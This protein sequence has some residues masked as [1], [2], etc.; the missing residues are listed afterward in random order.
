[1]IWRAFP[2]TLAVKPTWKLTT[3]N[4]Y[5]IYKNLGYILIATN[6]KYDGC[7]DNHDYIIAQQPANV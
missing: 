7:S 6:N 1:M 3:L 5:N 4:V 2:S